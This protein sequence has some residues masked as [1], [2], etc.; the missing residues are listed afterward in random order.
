VTVEARVRVDGAAGQ[1]AVELV[2]ILWA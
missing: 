1:N 2:F